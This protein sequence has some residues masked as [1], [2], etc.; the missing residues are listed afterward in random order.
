VRCLREPFTPAALLAVVNEC[1]AEA[2][3]CFSGA[4][5][6]TTDSHATIVRRSSGGA[7]RSHYCMDGSLLSA[8]HPA[9]VAYGSGDRRL[10]RR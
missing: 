2:R 4:V 3:S 7:I 5:Q 9:S 6:S 8:G 1:L 10:R